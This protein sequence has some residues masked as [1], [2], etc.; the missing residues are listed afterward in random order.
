MAASA[1]RE[2]GCRGAAGDLPGVGSD[3]AG[4]VS[5]FFYFFN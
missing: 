3:G 5:L 1:L 4:E 2:G